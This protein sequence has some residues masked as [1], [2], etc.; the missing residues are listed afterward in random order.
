M[1]E[2]V[3]RR[4]PPPGGRFDKLLRGG[5]VL[6]IADFPVAGPARGTVLLVTGRNEFIEKYYETIADLQDRGFDVH[7]M[8]WRGQG[9]SSRPLPDR[10]KGHVDDFADYVADLEAFADRI[11][12]RGP[13]ILMAHSMGGHIALRAL[14]TRPALR[15]RL[16]GAVLMSSMLAIDTGRVPS[17]I[18]GGIARVLAGLGLGRR[19]F[20]AKEGGGESV[21]T[22][23][24]ERGGDQAFFIAAEPRLDL[25][26]PTIGWLDAAFRS[27]ALLDAP[28]AVEG[29]DIPVL[30]VVAGADRVVRPD[31]Q[32]HMAGRLRAARVLEVEGARHE[33]LKERDPLRARFWAG[34]DDWMDAVAPANTAGH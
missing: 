7:M 9:L 20:P 24:P 21:L 29:I 4:Q 8:D 19:A 33:I 1:S 3:R 34:F 11:A 6:R 31:A 10:M 12:P 25:R 5:F 13:L 26:A 14:A 22:S 23:D 30:F 27:M 32:R 15:A 2:A 18:A 16:A 28:G 17:G